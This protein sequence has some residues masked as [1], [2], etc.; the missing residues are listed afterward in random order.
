MDLAKI[1][2]VRVISPPTADPMPV[3]PPLMM[4][5]A[6]GLIIGLGGSLAFIFLRDIFRPV[7]RTR[8]D[9]EVLLGVR[10]LASLPE[11]RALH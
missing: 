8:R 7:V 1:S 6:G 3:S 2:N 4:V 5:L 10:V 9:V 11:H